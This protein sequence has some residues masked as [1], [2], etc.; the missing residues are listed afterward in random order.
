MNTD[1]VL[2]VDVPLTDDF[3]GVPV[4]H[5]KTLEMMGVIVGMMNDRGITTMEAF[6]LINSMFLSIIGTVPA[7]FRWRARTQLI[8]MM[9]RAS[10]AQDAMMH[11][12]GP[13]SETTQ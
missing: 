7:E 12:I 5:K 2:R 10:I 6:T 4:D 11:S 13:S 9:L 8:T 3:A 1:D